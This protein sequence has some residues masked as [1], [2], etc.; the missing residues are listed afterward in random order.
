MR[1]PALRALDG[2]VAGFLCEL[3]PEFAFLVVQGFWEGDF[4]D[5]EE[6]AA[7]GALAR[8]AAAFELEALAGLRA[9]RQF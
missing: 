2:G 4:D 6:V 3:F 5:D 9:G 1:N 8:E 7:L